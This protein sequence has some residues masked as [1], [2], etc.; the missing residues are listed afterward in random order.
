ML[1]ITSL[2][3]ILLITIILF[4]WGRWRYDIVALIGLLLGVIVGVVPFESAF[5]GLG[6]PAVITVA[7]VMVIS[8]AISQTGILDYLIKYITPV[9]SNIYIHLLVLCSITAVLSAFMNNIGALALMLPVAIKTAE[10]NKRPAALV[11]MPI[12]LASALGGLTTVI[13][14]PP[15]L[16]IASFRAQITNHPFSMFDFTPVGLAVAIIGILFIALIGWRLLP[17]DREGTK[18]LDELFPLQDYIT[19]IKVPSESKMIGKTV[20]DLEDII[21]SELIIIGL[22]RRKQKRLVISRDEILESND[23]LIIEIQHDDLEKLLDKGK[24]DLVHDK[25]S[26]ENLRSDEIRLIEAVVPQGSRAEGRSSQ[27]LRLRSRYNI[28]LLAIS[29]EGK[30]FKKRLNHVNL[31]AGDVILLQ[32]HA[33]TLAESTVNLGFL[34]LQEHDKP[35]PATRNAILSL[36][37][38]FAAIVL[39][40]LHI[41]PIQIAFTVVVVALVLT[42]VIPVRKI[43]ASIDWPIIVLLAAMIPLGSALE[44]TGATQA[45]VNTI[46]PLAKHL[47]L[48]ATLGILMIITMTLSDFMNNAAT[49]VVMAP[50]AIK[51]AEALHISIDP[52]L[53]TVAIAASCSFLTPI[54]HQNNTLVMG[55]GGYKFYDYIRLGLPLEILVVLVSLPMIL[56]VWH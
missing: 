3:I 17:A 32:G 11:L 10:K 23:V 53:M 30:A 46:L 52:F 44:T 13:G 48:Y 37:F 6:N 29:R 7:C 55:P 18:S 19:E 41:L 28:N 40:T 8:Y 26:S 22:I 50:I 49:T 36:G 45:I 42:K 14:T 54:G 47:P 31:C 39:A 35:Q 38:F 24:L 33:D 5:S 21:D 51:L 2:L 4:I 9:S 56:L 16:L 43:Y 12:A 25:I 20:K 1:Q 27:G 34:P 15:N